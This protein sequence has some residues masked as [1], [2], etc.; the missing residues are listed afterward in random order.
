MN[1][2]LDKV[3][4]FGKAIIR[5]ICELE[6]TYGEVE[7]AFDCILESMRMHYVLESLLESASFGVM[8]EAE[9]IL[10]EADGN[11]DQ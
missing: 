5:K 6:M 7:D 3:L 1:D 8:R 2:E 10:K 11:G 4:E 9:Q